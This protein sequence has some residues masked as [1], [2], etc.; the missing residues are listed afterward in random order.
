MKKLLL[1]LLLLSVTA[2]CEESKESEIMDPND[3]SFNEYVHKTLPNELL[4]RIKATTDVF[5][6]VDGVSYEEAVDLYKRDYDPESNLIIWEE[7]ARVYSLFCNS[8]CTTH[9]ERLEV[10][11][12]LLLRS[13]FTKK[14]TLSQM[15]Y[16]EL[17]IKEAEYILSQYGMEPE[18]L[19]IIKE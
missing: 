15:E 6:I 17:T 14:D 9:E 16:T 2:I 18:P 5:E 13:M 1:I 11:K 4:V 8:R 12:T 19:G 7:M 3:I 10:Y